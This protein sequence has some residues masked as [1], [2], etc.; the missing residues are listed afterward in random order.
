MLIKHEA[1][2]TDR[3]KSVI[4]VLSSPAGENEESRQH[5]IV[6]ALDLLQNLHDASCITGTASDQPF[7]SQRERKLVH[8]LLDLVVLEGIYPSL[9]PGVGLPMEQRVKSAL[10][11]HF[12]TRPLTQH[13][14]GQP[15]DQQLLALILDRLYPMLLSRKGVA[16]SMDTRVS[17]DLIAA[18]AELAYSPAF[19]AESRQAY[20]SKF[21]HLL[22][23]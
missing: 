4:H 1:N 13:H 3:G 21:H 12:V 8:T 10:N 2:R 22:D 15:R 20:L 14:G 6:R 5:V 23:R 17:V 18:V 19:A 11:G 7:A 16:P 9:S